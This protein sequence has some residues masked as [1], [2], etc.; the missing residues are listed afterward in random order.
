MPILYLYSAKFKMICL[1]NVIL[2][3]KFLTLNLKNGI[4]GQNILKAENY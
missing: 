1:V 4:W 3:K 2:K